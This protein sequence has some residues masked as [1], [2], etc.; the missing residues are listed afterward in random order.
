MHSSH[1]SYDFLQFDI[2]VHGMKFYGW[3]AI[4]IFVIVKFC[5]FFIFLC[6]YN[7]DKNDEYQYYNNDDKKLEASVLANLKVRFICYLM[8]CLRSR[9][10]IWSIQTSRRYLH[11]ILY[12]SDPGSNDPYRTNPGGL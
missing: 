5:Y 7:Y 1:L 6:F 8:Q 10:S 3:N 2:M 12:P 4:L 9:N 11:T